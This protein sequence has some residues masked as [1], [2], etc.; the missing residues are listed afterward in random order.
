MKV[1]NK[2]ETAHSPAEIPND[3]FTWKETDKEAA[4]VVSRPSL[5]YW[6]DAWKR[7]VKN[8]L[9]MAGLVFLVLLT[10]M[11]IFGPII[12]PYTVDKTNLPNQFQPPSGDHWFGTDSLGRDVFTRTWFG[13]RISL[14]VGLMAALID[15]TIGIIY[16]GISGYKGGRA[17]N[18][19]MRIIEILYGLPYLLV[20]ILLLVVLG[21]SLGTIILAL[22][23]TG[24]VGMARIVRG[25]VLQIK[26]YE[27]V[28][29][30]RSFG[31]KTSRIIRKNLIPNTMGPIIVQMTLTVPSAIFAEAFL[32]FLGL[33]IQSPH[34]SW[35]MMA[36]DA[37][38]AILSG[39][40]WTLFFPAFFISFT[41]FAFNVLGD[42]LQDALDPKLRK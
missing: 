37:L 33:G 5:S 7:L 39:H 35:G 42:G 30:S 19:M 2:I 9:A 31:T 41:M 22:T 16:G 12:S 25:Q 28:L 18:I 29:A 10:I 6:Q 23:V 20:V 4:E 11:A 8:K 26:N 24:W 27:F 3:W 36:N 38:G 1:A 15:F 13:A 14:F 34:A 21:P 32:S 40:W 17:D